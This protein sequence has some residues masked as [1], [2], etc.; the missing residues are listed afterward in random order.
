[1]PCP[2]RFFF[3][4]SSMRPLLRD[5]AI[6]LSHLIMLLLLLLLLLLLPL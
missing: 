4:F 5:R 6:S 2:L 1:M 3:F